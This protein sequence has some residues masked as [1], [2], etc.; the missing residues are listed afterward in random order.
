MGPVA[1]L[2]S[3]ARDGTVCEITGDGE[4]DEDACADGISS[5]EGCGPTAIGSQ[6]DGYLA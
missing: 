1:R 6:Q 4:T 5:E 3:S 2:R